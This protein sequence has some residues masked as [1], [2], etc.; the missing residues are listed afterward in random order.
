MTNLD[1]RSHMSE[2]K[3]AR[4]LLDREL[5]NDKSQQEVESDDSGPG[6]PS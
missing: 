5:P 4:S 2:M 1:A 6:V 3:L